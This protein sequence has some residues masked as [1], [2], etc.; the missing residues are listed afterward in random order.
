M[1]VLIFIAALAL[2]PACTEAQ[3][4]T[5]KKQPPILYLDPI[6]FELGE[7]EEEDET[8]AGPADPDLEAMGGMYFEIGDVTISGEPIEVFGDEEIITMD[9][10]I[11]LGEAWID[12]NP[13]RWYWPTD[14]RIVTSGFG[15]RKLRNKTRTE[16]CRRN[17]SQAKALGCKFHTGLDITGSRSQKTFT[18]ATAS[19]TVTFSGNNGGGG[20]T[21]KID[22]GSGLET[23]YSHHAELFVKAGEKV[24]AGQIL[25]E[26]GST[27]HSTGP[28]LHIAVKK[29]GKFQNPFNYITP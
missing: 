23:I 18:Y 12:R 1:R 5:H 4:A 16:R 13:K 8:D 19:G 10:T 28:H 20:K 24:D 21:V 6:D 27:G 9:F 2:L 14:L 26:V 3:A 29:N 15:W 11:S 22:H 25:G 17:P 7:I